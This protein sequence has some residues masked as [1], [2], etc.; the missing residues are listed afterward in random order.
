[1]LNANLDA[2]VKTGIINSSHAM[3]ESIGN[4]PELTFHQSRVFKFALVPIL[5]SKYF[6][7]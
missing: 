5:S 4:R 7:A 6:E 1:M 3:F 2:T